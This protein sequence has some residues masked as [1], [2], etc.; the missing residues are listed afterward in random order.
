MKTQQNPKGRPVQDEKLSAT[1]VLKSI[2][3]RIYQWLLPDGEKLPPLIF[4]GGEKI[5]SGTLHGGEEIKPGTLH[6]GEEI[7]PGTL[8]GGEECIGGTL[9][10]PYYPATYRTKDG[11][12]FYKFNYVEVGNHFEVDILNQ[13]SYGSRCSDMSV[14]H[15]LSSA[16]GGKKICISAGKEPTDI[17]SA[18]KISIEWAELTHE[19]IKTGKTIDQQVSKRVHSTSTRTNT[20]SSSGLLGWLFN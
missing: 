7:Q 5:L 4:I 17:E 15:W 19:Y 8:H 18:K 1:F 11:T 20:Q 12:A 3:L 14:A 9:C 16:R 10:A 2:F 13:P 6:G